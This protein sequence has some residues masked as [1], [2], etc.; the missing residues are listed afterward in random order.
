M[1]F[2][3]TETLNITED[4][5]IKF[6]QSQGIE[7]KT[8][9]RARGNLGIC[10]KNRIDVSKKLPRD[11]RI[12]V[13][14]H[15]YAHK[16]HHDLEQNSLKN[17]GSLG[18]LF[19]TDNIE[20][21][22]K[23]LTRVTYF[24]DENA[25]FLEYKSMRDELLDK[26]KELTGFIKKEYPDFKRSEEFKPIK[27]YFKKHKSNAR[28]LLKY[29][30]VKLISPVFRREE[31]VSIAS[32]DEN[33]PEIPE[34]FRNY[35][36][37]ISFQRKLKKLSARKNRLDK[38]YKRSTELFAR[39]VEGLFFDKEK[40]KLIAPYTFKRFVFLL[41]KNYYGSLKELMSKTGI[42]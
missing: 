37:L 26:I 27:Q 23:E 29:D 42:L 2:M 22:E 28:Y 11:R 9:T 34:V 40:V 41:E 3:S 12:R 5:I 36:K 16:V 15:E 19:N 1:I 14:A 31:L 24:V 32:V 39:F 4:E 7:V 30:H 8:N 18:V 21:I 17:G 6:I 38:Y 13:L 33:F 10:L 20:I 35:L 25:L